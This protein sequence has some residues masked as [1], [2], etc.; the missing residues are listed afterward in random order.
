MIGDIQ[1]G[2]VQASF[3][4]KKPLISSG[5]RERVGFSA[6]LNFISIIIFVIAL[7]VFGG[8]TFY[9]TV[10]K[11]SIANIKAD[12]EKVQNNFKEEDSAMK[13]MIRFDAKLNNMNA[14][15]DSHISLQN[16][17]GFLEDSTMSKLRYTEFAYT[18]KGNGSADLKLGGEAKSYSDIALQAEQFVNSKMTGNKDFSNIIFSDFNPGLTGNVVFKATANIDPEFIHYK[19]LKALQGGIE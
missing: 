10:L 15:L 13:E 7:S 4:P 1:R 11:S 19:N 5:Q 3:I 14:L 9:K 8:G 12:L 17:F 18:N 6:I 2:G 16:L